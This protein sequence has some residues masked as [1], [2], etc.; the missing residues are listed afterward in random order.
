MFAANVHIERTCAIATMRDALGASWWH[1]ESGG[2][3]VLC[4]EM[5]CLGVEV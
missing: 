1:S 3:V 4:L 2:E 5:V